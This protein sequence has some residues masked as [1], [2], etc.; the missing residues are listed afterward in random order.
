MEKD[1]KKKDTD[2]TFIS[3]YFILQHCIGN[4]ETRRVLSNVTL[5]NLC[6]LKINIL[7]VKSLT[8]V[9]T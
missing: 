3:S 5:G 4:N 1:H 6:Y 2:T 7:G 8:T 9:K